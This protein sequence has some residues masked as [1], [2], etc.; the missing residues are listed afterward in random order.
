MYYVLAT[1]IVWSQARRRPMLA[2][3]ALA[4]VLGKPPF[5]LPLLALLLIC[6][7]WSVVWRG[8]AIFVA[9]CVPVLI[10]L[11]VDEGSPKALYHAIVSNLRYS[12]HAAVD[13][14]GA[15]RRIDAVSLIGRYV[16]D[17]SGV[18]QLAAFIVLV[19]LAGLVLRRKAAEPG[20]NPTPA[21]LL[22][23][24]LSTLLSIVHQDYDLLLLAWPFAAALSLALRPGG[25]GA[26][27]ALSLS[28]PALA[29]SF[30]PA[31]TTAS[32]LGLSSGVGEITTLTTACLLLAMA[33]A[34][35][36]VFLE[37]EP[38]LL[39]LDR[40]SNGALSPVVFYKA[41]TEPT[42]RN[43]DSRQVQRVP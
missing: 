21:V 43:G 41:M 30:I 11:S 33:G 3:L 29:A 10:W 8:V 1:Y 27:L 22:V 18:W 26:R 13:R 16:H 32:I 7:A 36:A 35:V 40:R 4:V 28:L 5:G 24:G 15:V 6:R 14:V 17:I 38:P 23:L 37:S 19:G 25:R 31:A 20:W 39:P 42:R 12:N 2:A 34:L 9:A